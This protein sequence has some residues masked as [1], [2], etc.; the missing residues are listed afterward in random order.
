[1]DKLAWASFS[2]ISAASFFSIVA[3]LANEDNRGLAKLG[4][5]ALVNVR[6]GVVLQTNAV[7]RRRKMPPGIMIARAAKQR[8]GV[9]RRS[10]ID[11]FDVI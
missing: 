11:S 2:I 5:V 4:P 8:D 10:L 3:G 7:V 9:S 6:W 1:M